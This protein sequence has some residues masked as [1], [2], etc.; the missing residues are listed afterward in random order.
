MLTFDRR[1]YLTNSMSGAPFDIMKMEKSLELYAS[2]F[3]DYSFSPEMK[4]LVERSCPIFTEIFNRLG[5]KVSETETFEVLMLV[6]TVFTSA[7]ASG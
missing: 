1:W 4:Y 7:S 6:L 3:K 5:M 2:E